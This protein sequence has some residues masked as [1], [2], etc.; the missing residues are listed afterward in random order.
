MS[1]YQDALRAQ[2]LREGA[3]ERAKLEMEARGAQTY[4]DRLQ[5][6]VLREE[7]EKWRRYEM[8]ATRA[9]QNMG[10]PWDQASKQ[11]A[12][13]LK[14]K[15]K[16]ASK[17]AKDIEKEITRRQVAEQKEQARQQ[18]EG[19]E[20]RIA[21]L[22]GEH[23]RPPHKF[24]WDALHFSLPPHPPA[25]DSRN[26]HRRTVETV[27]LTRDYEE[28]EAK[29]EAAWATDQE[30]FRESH[31]RYQ[32]RH[33]NWRRQK[34]LAMR[35][36]AGDAAALMEAHAEVATN[37]GATVTAE[38][39]LQPHD[40]ARIY[41]AVRVA[42]RDVIPEETQSLTQSGKV[43]TKSMSQ[44]KAKDLYEDHVCSRCLAVGRQLFAA[45]PVAEVIVTAYATA[46]NTGTGNQADVPIVSAH[47]E[48][49]RFQSLDFE[50]LDPSDALQSFRYTGDVRASKRGEGFKAVQPLAFNHTQTANAPAQTL[51]EMCE[52]INSLREALAKLQ[53]KTAQRPQLKNNL[54]EAS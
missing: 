13:E 33:E 26:H 39:A 34:T 51:E 17:T 21:D 7:V 40:S 24:D 42:G 14:Q 31:S 25:F 53:P 22:V 3:E 23:K 28:F 46:T 16:E 29:L 8:E 41:A 52:A 4:Q 6:E 19:F 48:R 37:T 44:N 2:V 11:H 49:D 50:S 18:V 45:L 20:S 54:T 15:A 30:A 32:Q 27:L 43:T 9:L 36:R 35:L 47:F 12:R 5:Q 38:I 1:D 10:E